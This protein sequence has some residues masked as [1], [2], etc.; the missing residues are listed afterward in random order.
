MAR[1]R[2]KQT[3]KLSKHLPP[4]RCTETELR[5]ILAKS[6][7]ANMTLSAYI[8]SASVRS[9][10]VVKKSKWDPQLYSEIRRIGVNVNQA[11]RLAHSHGTSPKGLE[12]VWE[13][14][15]LLLEEMMRDGA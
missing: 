5:E 15:Q 14:L 8:R 3:E 9:K 2:K 12:R 4:A 13:R 11:M 10:I 1:P 6:K 7:A